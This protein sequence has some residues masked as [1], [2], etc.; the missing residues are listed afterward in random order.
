MLFLTLGYCRTFFLVFLRRITY[1]IVLFE[2]IWVHKFSISL[3]AHWRFGKF[4]FEKFISRKKNKVNIYFEFWSALS[5]LGGSLYSEI[6][7]LINSQ[8]V[9]F[10]YLLSVCLGVLLITSRIYCFFSVSVPSFRTLHTLGVNIYIKFID[11]KT[12]QKTLSSCK[13]N[14]LCASW[15]KI[16]LIFEY[17]TKPT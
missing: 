7:S 16:N 13:K 5:V 17:T 11:K 2:H 10:L 12:L 3:C 15:M 1:Y 4:Q 8:E 14:A 6:V 9:L